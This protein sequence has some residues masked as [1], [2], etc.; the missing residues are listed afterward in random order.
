[1]IAIVWGVRAF[2]Q[3]ELPDGPTPRASIRTLDAEMRELGVPTGRPVLL[4]FW[5]SW[6]GV[7]KAMH[8]QLDDLASEHDVVTIASQSGSAAEVRAFLAEQGWRAASTAIDADG[9]LARRFGVTAFPTTF[10]LDPTGAIRFAEVG[11]TTMLG[12]QA[13]LWWA[14]L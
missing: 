4:H 2:Q 12:L 8:P 10:V 6:C 5:A 11:Y 7:C 1:M 14:S 13:R 9:R 3:R